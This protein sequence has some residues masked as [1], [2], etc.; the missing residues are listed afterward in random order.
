MNSFLKYQQECRRSAEQPLH[1]N[2]ARQDGMPF[3]GQPAL[4]RD[5]EYDEFTEQVKDFDAGLFHMDSPEELA[6]MRGVLD[7]V[8]NGWY[9]VVDYDKQWVDRPEG[10]KTV[11]IYLLWYVPYRQ[12]DEQKAMSVLG[13]HTLGS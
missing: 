5:E 12:L 1:W 4:L 2:R 9:K 6:K 8:C 13:A 11:C 10:K 3:R 7:K